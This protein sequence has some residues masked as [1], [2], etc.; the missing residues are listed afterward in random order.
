MK[1]S[2]KAPDIFPGILIRTINESE[3]KSSLSLFSYLHTKKRLIPLFLHPYLARRI[4]FTAAY[5]KYLIFQ[6]GIFF[7]SCICPLLKALLQLLSG[8]GK[9]CGYAVFL[10]RIYHK[11]DHSPIRKS[12]MDHAFLLSG[13]NRKKITP[14]RCEELLLGAACL[15]KKGGQSRH[16][17]RIVQ[18]YAFLSRF[19]LV[20][21]EL[22]QQFPRHSRKQFLPISL[23]FKNFLH[24]HLTLLP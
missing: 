7:Q 12:R 13:V 21:V 18:R 22:R 3:G 6:T 8:F 11:G 23:Y 15:R 5:H 19:L 10:C 1:C 9:I 4:I 17:R 20:A 2:R 24:K 14:C 16:V